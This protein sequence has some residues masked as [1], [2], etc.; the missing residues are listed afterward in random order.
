MYNYN[1]LAYSFKFSAAIYIIVF[2]YININIPNH[3]SLINI[4]ILNPNKQI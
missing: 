4:T 3:A 1:N 2:L